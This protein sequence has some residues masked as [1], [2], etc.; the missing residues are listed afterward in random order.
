MWHCVVCLTV[1][2]LCSLLKSLPPLKGSLTELWLAWSRTSLSAG[3]VVE[4]E[5]PWLCSLCSSALRTAGTGVFWVLWFVLVPS[6]LAAPALVSNL[7]SFADNGPR[8]G[9]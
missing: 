5:A 9:H 3:Y 8:G 2:R 4:G 7:S 1:P 6:A